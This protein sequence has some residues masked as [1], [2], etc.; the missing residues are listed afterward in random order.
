MVS[1][2][3]ITRRG[4]FS[5]VVCSVRL[6]RNN[7]TWI[8][9]N[10]ERLATDTP[11]LWARARAALKKAGLP[12]ALESIVTAQCGG[13]TFVRT[14]TGA[15]RDTEARAFC[16][17]VRSGTAAEVLGWLFDQAAIAVDI[18]GYLVGLALAAACLYPI[19]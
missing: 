16:A 15:A 2:C 14:L 5:K 12:K 13:R 11:L 3:L 17:A 6:S 19:N 4:T 8:E 1:I 7:E 9:I 18:L 10:G